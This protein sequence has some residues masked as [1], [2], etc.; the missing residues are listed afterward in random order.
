MPTPDTDIVAALHDAVGDALRV[1]GF[2]DGTEWHV[3]Y[4]REDV[5][6]A[7]GDASIDDIADDLVLDVLSSPRQESLYDLGSLQA[8]SRLFED[9]LVVHVPTDERSGYLVSLDTGSDA[10]GRDVVDVVRDATE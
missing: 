9:G 6:E 7:Y 4:M 10:T 5:R 3:E 8:T 1:A 2:H